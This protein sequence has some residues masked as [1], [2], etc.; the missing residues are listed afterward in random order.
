MAL[1]SGTF[2]S[3][4]VE[5]FLS[6]HLTHSTSSSAFPPDSARDP[7]VA[8]RPL[9]L[10]YAWSSELA[11]QKFHDAIY[12]SANYLKSI[13]AAEQGESVVSSV[14][15]NNYAMYDTP[16]ESLYGENVP[17]LQALAQK[18]DPQSVMR[19]AGGFKL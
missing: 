13:I 2:A 5:P 8:T 7:S 1:T 11:D 9:N 18:Y 12:A 14:I 3:Y 6:T 19:L 17:T 10:Y 15:Y 16:L 4:D